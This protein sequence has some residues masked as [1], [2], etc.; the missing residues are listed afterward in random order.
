MNFLEVRSGLRKIFHDLPPHVAKV[1][2]WILA[3][4]WMKAPSEVKAEMEHEI[5]LDLKTMEPQHVKQ[6]ILAA[7]YGGAL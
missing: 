7:N 3:L 1:E 4:A 2:S 6:D 5:R